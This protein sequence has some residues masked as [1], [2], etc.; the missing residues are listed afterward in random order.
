MT[1]YLRTFSLSLGFKSMKKI[2]SDAAQRN[3]LL[4]RAWP[5]MSV[6]VMANFAFCAQI[7]FCVSVKGRFEIL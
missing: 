1:K 7:T 4:Y 3:C 5:K 2:D 6:G